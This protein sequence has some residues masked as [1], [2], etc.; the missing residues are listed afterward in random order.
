MAVKGLNILI[1]VSLFYANLSVSQTDQENHQKYWY[2][3][4][5]LNNDFVKVG[6]DAG[7][8]IPFNQR[9]TDVT[10]FYPANA[11]LKAGDATATLV[12]LPCLQPNIIY[13]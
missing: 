3:K 7:E 8:S 6:L 2:Y 1:F 11:L 10:D 12:I 9:G 4:T 13:W 5:R